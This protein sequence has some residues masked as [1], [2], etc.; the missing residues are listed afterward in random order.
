MN[1]D[2]FKRVFLPTR[3]DSALRFV[4]SVERTFLAP[5]ESFAR[6]AVSTKRNSGEKITFCGYLARWRLWDFILGETATKRQFTYF[7]IDEI[8]C[9]S[10]F[11]RKSE[12]QWKKRPSNLNLYHTNL[13]HISGRFWSSQ[14]GAMSL[15]PHWS[16]CFAPLNSLDT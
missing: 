16:R 15:F 9:S 5:G 1:I 10:H 12:V 8:L 14:K 7:E 13:E 11:W 2:G 4:S 6:R 3:V